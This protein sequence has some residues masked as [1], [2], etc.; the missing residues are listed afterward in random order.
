M[1][2]ADIRPLHLQKEFL[3]LSREDI[4]EF[5][6]DTVKRLYCP[7]PACKESKDFKN[8]FTKNGF[9]YVECLKCGTLF[10]N[11]RPPESAINNYYKRSKATKYWAE[12]L[13][14]ETEE[15]RRKEI[16]SPK[17][18]MV[19]DL[20]REASGD[21]RME[22]LLDVGMGYGIFGEEVQKINF[23][24]EITGVEPSTYLAAICRE[25]GFSII[26]MAVEKVKEPKNYFKAATSFEV[27][28]HLFSPE[29][30]LRAINGLL[31]NNGYL[32][33]TTLN[34]NGFELLNLWNKSDSIFPPHH[35]NFFNV[36]SLEILLDRTG[37]RVIKSFTPGKLD[38]NII[39]NNIDLV[40]QNRFIRY[41]IKKSP[42]SV[43]ENFQKFL[44]ENNLSSHMCMLAQKL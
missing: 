21:E 6:N 15:A 30:F 37:Y 4:K 14:K 11:P 31:A 5:F 42:T 13:F 26:E 1:K 32:I 36:E 25:K 7:C 9:V 39:E 33:L 24:N 35:I 23:F 8:Q 2:E 22:N 20:L 18:K 16:F 12:H 44:Q 34:I 40:S 27:I 28:E 41:L 19:V 29:K 17:A 10:A 3:R 38:V 43:K